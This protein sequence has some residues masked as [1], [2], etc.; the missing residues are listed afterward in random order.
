[1]ATPEPDALREAAYFVER[2]DEEQM[3]L[4][5]LILNRVARSRYVD[6]SAGRAAAAAEAL[7]S[8]P[9]QGLSA[10][11]L[12]L[13]AERMQAVTHDRRMRDRFVSAHPEVPV[14][15]IP[16]RPVDVRDLPALRDLAAALAG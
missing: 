7:Q 1:V 3:P 6:I 4:A 12:E 5:G 15:E 10:A 14:A 13:H 2:L 8:Q 9:G 16:A 11:L